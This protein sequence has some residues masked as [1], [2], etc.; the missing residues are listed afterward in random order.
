LG[1]SP[2]LILNLNVA[3]RSPLRAVKV[4][5]V[6]PSFVPLIVVV[7]AVGGSIATIPG[8]PAA[9]EDVSVS[10]TLAIR[11]IVSL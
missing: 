10:L 8:V 4:I 11:V 1:L 6:S 7:S 5:S 2:T 9:H 3:D